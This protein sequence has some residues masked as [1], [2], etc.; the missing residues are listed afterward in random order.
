LELAGDQKPA[1]TMFIVGI[2]GKEISL[3][4][5][6]AAKYLG[7]PD[8]KFQAEVIN[9]SRNILITGDDFA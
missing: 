2:N 6:L 8:K 1:D 4:G 7:E 5:S 9:L 3:S